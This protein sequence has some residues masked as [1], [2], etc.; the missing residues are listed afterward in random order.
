M[1]TI[2]DFL[3]PFITEEDQDTIQLCGFLLNQGATHVVVSELSESD[4]FLIG[5]INSGSN[6]A[7]WEVLYTNPSWSVAGMPETSVWLVN[8]QPGEGA[9]PETIVALG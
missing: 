5:V 6:G 4:H 2:Q 9:Y 1:Q 7:N 3:A 8:A